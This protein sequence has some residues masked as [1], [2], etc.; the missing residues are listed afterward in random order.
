MTLAEVDAVDNGHRILRPFELATEVLESRGASLV[1][2]A[3]VID[4]LLPY[5]T[6]NIRVNFEDRFRE[7]FYCV[8]FIVAATFYATFT[9]WYAIQVPTCTLDLIIYAFTV[10]AET[11][12]LKGNMRVEVSRLFNG[13]KRK[14]T[15]E[16]LSVEVGKTIFT[17]K[18]YLDAYWGCMRTLTRDYI[19]LC[20]LYL[21]VR[22]MTATEAACER[23]FS[24]QGV[25]HSDFRNRLAPE[26]LEALMVVATQERRPHQQQ[27]RPPS[28]EVP[29]GKKCM[30]LL[31]LIGYMFNRDRASRLR[32]GSAVVVRHLE[33][34]NDVVETEYVVKGRPAT[35]IET[36]GVNKWVIELK[37]TAGERKKR[38]KKSEDDQFF[39]YPSLRENEER[40]D[41]DFVD[42]D[43]NYNELV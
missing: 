27:Y 36:T 1:D 7:H 20:D 41:W 30:P 23:A 34:D 28:F 31:N 13:T 17:Y 43:L 38:T 29:T 37:T 6:S 32:E 3:A 21:R 11:Y 2:T 26:T 33:D 39:L 18:E 4:S 15:V 25:V 24:L 42:K 35:W 14:D 5:L 12:E 8:P 19:V 9:D 22:A 10:L 16:A 40:D